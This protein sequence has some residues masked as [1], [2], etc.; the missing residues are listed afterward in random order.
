MTSA[1]EEVKEKQLDNIRERTLIAIGVTP[2]ELGRL[3]L[4]TVKKLEDQLD[5][6]K[7]QYFAH[8]GT[9]CDTRVDDD[10]SLQQKAAIE[11][12]KMVAALAGLNTRQQATESKTNVTLDLS[13]W[14]VNTADGPKPVTIEVPTE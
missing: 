6:Q 7:I 9:V 1:L 10:G 3:W 2:E 4:K 13:G 14:S 5:A 8:E 11:L 12:N